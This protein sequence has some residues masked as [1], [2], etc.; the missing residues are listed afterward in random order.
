MAV[1]GN[2]MRFEPM[3]SLAYGDI[4]DTYA[5]VGAPAS[6]AIHQFIVS[7]DTDVTLT[8]SFD[9]VNDHFVLLAGSQFV[10]DV[11]ANKSS[12]HLFMGVGDALHVRYGGSGPSSGSVYFSTMY[13]STKG[14]PNF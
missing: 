12:N 10:S 11:N 5:V 14:S 8:F 13:G 6:P 1:L 4:S 2:Y 9:G 7:N 3:R